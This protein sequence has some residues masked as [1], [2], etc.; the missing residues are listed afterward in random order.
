MGARS[1]SR[2]PSA[3]LPGLCPRP[4]LCRPSL[5]RGPSHCHGAHPLPWWPASLL[6]PD[7]E[8]ET[9]SGQETWTRTCVCPGT[10]RLKRGARAL[11]SS[12]ST[13][14]EACPRAL[15]AV[16]RTGRVLHGSLGL[17]SRCVPR[18]LTGQ[19]WAPSALP[20][21]ALPLWPLHA[22]VSHA[23]SGQN[24]PS[25]GP[26]VHGQASPC[27]VAEVWRAGCGDDTSRGCLLP[28]WG[29]PERGEVWV[30][31]GQRVRPRLRRRSPE[32]GGTQR[33]AGWGDGD[34]KSLRRLAALPKWKGFRHSLA[35]ASSPT[36]DHGVEDGCLHLPRLRGL[37]IHTHR[38]PRL[39][40]DIRV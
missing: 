34:L 33:Q 31:E 24:P 28:A 2:R 29:A 22:T 3:L 32:P 35:C 5:C 10:R 39:V 25:S 7:Q 8:H 11:A 13:Q 19:E 17:L 9:S 12:S 1:Q 18:G 27:P 36:K 4:F 6:E 23:Q 40:C 38:G 37:R 30:T 20:A 21:P 26:R 16:L 15:P 14:Q